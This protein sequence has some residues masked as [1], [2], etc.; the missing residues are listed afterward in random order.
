MSRLIWWRAASIVACVSFASACGTIP[1]D[2]IG[3]LDRARTGDLVVGVSEHQP[4]TEVS[5]KGE[6]SGSEVELIKGFAESID[7]DVEWYSAPES[8]LADKIKEEQLD[9]VIGG[10]TT[11]SPW[12]THMALTRPYTKVD[13]ESMVMGTRLGEN[14]LMVALERYLAKEFG[15]IS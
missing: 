2:S 10:L 3:T 12:S 1:A 11:T 6:Y 4:W 5:D 13:G 14:E 15:E 7:A 9:I 8:V